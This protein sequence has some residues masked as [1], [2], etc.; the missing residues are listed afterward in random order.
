MFIP[1][2]LEHHQH[3]N[4]M[5]TSGSYPILHDAPDHLN[6]HPKTIGLFILQRLPLLRENCISS[7]F[8]KDYRAWRGNRKFDKYFV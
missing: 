8:R 1:P 3:S 4:I 2:N 5:Q 7:A 6:D